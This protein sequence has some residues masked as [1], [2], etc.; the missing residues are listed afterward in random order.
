MVEQ[1][2]IMT[3]IYGEMANFQ[4]SWSI[5]YW[6]MDEE[7]KMTWHENYYELSDAKTVVDIMRKEFPNRMVKILRYVDY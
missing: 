6:N 4:S 1:M 2:A 3:S 7:C 5:F